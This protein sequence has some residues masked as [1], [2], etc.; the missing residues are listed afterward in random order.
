M[1]ACAHFLAWNHIVLQESEEV[2]YQLL[3]LEPLLIN[4]AILVTYTLHV[5]S[6][7]LSSSALTCTLRL[8]LEVTNKVVVLGI[9]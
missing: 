3:I 4:I 1:K 9:A 8:V 2:Y 6:L 5:L 7:S